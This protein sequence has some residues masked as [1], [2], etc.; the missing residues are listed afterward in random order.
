MLHVIITCHGVVVHR[1]LRALMRLKLCKR[2]SI[3]PASNAVGNPAIQLLYGRHISNECGP[4]Y[5]HSGSLSHLSR[6]AAIVPGKFRTNF[7]RQTRTAP[8]GQPASQPAGAWL[9]GGVASLLL[10]PVLLEA[11]ISIYRGA[12]W[13]INERLFL[14]LSEVDAVVQLGGVAKRASRAVLATPQRGDVGARCGGELD[15]QR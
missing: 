12:L 15:D 9:T 10:H 8:I 14:H 7:L 2:E 13:L 5:T 1:L 6:K 4:K 3:L 11:I